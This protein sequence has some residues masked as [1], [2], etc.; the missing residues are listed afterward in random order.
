MLLAFRYHYN[1]R[2][3]NTPANLVKV[4]SSNKNECHDVDI[5]IVNA[6]Q[7]KAFNIAQ[8][9]DA[10]LFPIESVQ[11]LD[12]LYLFSQEDLINIYQSVAKDNGLEV[13]TLSNNQLDSLPDLI[14]Y[15]HEATLK[16]SN[17]DDGIRKNKLWSWVILW[18]E[19]I[20]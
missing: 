9:D 16:Q 20:A 3:E 5:K 12:T 15:L 1:T 14:L 19:T 11:A 18:N 10:E 4:C 7:T 17:A 2:K 6:V 8:N 13:E